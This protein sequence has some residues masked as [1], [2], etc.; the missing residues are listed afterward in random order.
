MAEL[1]FRTAALW[2]WPVPVQKITSAPGLA[3]P[4]VCLQ[5]G[6]A[7]VGGLQAQQEQGEC[8]V[9]SELLSRLAHRPPHVVIAGAAFLASAARGAR[10]GTAWLCGGAR[11]AT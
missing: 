2:L 5:A 8:S 6:V 7:A 3:W 11:V 9:F 1:G 10:R 4:Q